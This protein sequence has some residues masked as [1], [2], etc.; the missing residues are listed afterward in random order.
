MVNSEVSAKVSNVSTSLKYS[1]LT[2]GKLEKSEG[3]CVVLTVAG[4]CF[5]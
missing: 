1:S 4:S 2:N 5:G 3:G